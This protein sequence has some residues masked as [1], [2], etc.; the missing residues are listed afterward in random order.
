MHSVLLINKLD[1]DKLHFSQC[2]WIQLHLVNDA[3]H[4]LFDK[5]AEYNSVELLSSRNFW[6]KSIFLLNILIFGKFY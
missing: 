3:Q 4:Y 1:L 6:D 5:G 2:L